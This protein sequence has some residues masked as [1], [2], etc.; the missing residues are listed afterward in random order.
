MSLG[1]AGVV[2]LREVGSGIG[3]GT[4][5]GFV[6]SVAIVVGVSVALEVRMLVKAACAVRRVNFRICGGMS[7]A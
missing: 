4:E 1:R 7:G 5:T 6:E 2:L 3:M